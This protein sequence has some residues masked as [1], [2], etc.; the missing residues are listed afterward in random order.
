M[1]DTYEQHSKRKLAT[2]VLAVL[3]I[4]GIVVMADH[5]KSSKASGNTIVPTPTTSQSSHQTLSTPGTSSS[6]SSSSLKDGAYSASS[7]YFVPHG[8]ESIK[9]SLTLS[10]GTITDVSVQNSEDDPT[11]A[12]Y[13]EDFSASYKSAVLGK[14]IDGLQISNIAGASDTTQGFNDALGQIESQAQA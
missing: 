1:L 12:Q 3:V 8:N 11:S 6:S 7:D 13:Q 4:A 10:G 5:L 14:K 2:T 9:V